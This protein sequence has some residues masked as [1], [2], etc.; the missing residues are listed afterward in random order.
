M[1]KNDFWQ[2]GTMAIYYPFGTYGILVSNSIHLM[3]ALFKGGYIFMHKKYQE[4]I[5]KSYVIIFGAL[6]QFSH[7]FTDL[8]YSWHQMSASSFTLEGCFILERHEKNGRKLW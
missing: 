4:S 8:S 3:L 6:Q 1:T 7:L 5:S 2:L